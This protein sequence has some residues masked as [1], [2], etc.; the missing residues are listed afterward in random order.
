MGRTSRAL[1]GRPD[2]DGREALPHD[3][4]REVEQGGRDNLGHGSAAVPEE[5]SKEGGDDGRLSGSHDELMA[6]GAPGRMGMHE[7]P[8]EGHLCSIGH[9]QETDHAD[10]E[11][12]TS[13][14]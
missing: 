12:S 11:S 10:Q 2:E 3:P 6:Q 13:K 4:S 14:G 9:Q 1:M 8:N 7:A 5:K